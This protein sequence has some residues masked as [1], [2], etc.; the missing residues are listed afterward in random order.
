MTDTQIL[1]QIAA[2]RP[3]HVSNSKVLGATA[4]PAD[5]SASYGPEAW[6][7]ARRE[8]HGWDGYVSTPLV[9][10]NGLARELGLGGIFYKD[11][12]PRF[13]LGS[14]KALGGAYAVSRLLASMSDRDPAGITVATATDGNHGRSVAWGAHRFGCQC[15]IYM[16]AGVSQGR[17]DAVEAFGADVV[18][19][20]GNYDA[21]VQQAAEDAAREGWF[22][23]SD[24]SWPGYTELPGHVMAGYSVMMAEALDGMGDAKPTH[25]FAQGGVGGLAAAAVAY[26]WQRMGAERPRGVVV[27]PDRADCLFRSAAAGAATAME[28]SEETVMAGLSCGEP[29][30][31]AWPILEAAVSDFMS[32]SDDPVGPCMTLLARSPFGD[33]PVVAGESAVCGLAGLI[34][35]ARDDGLRGTLGLGPEACVLVIGTEGATDPAIYRAMT[36]LDPEA[37]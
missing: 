34:A 30:M 18:W 13:G 33:P 26:P 22:I 31:I 36:G 27:E 1:D 14:F 25:V 32:I 10:L 5:L 35:A 7:A 20:D 4:Y 6:D 23:V 16:H 2:V 11:E 21:S 19:V 24:T 29:S 12:G 17:A 8:I 37:V 15:K 9:S 28:I 3:A